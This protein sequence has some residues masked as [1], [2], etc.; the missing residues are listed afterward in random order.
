MVQQMNFEKNAKGVPRVRIELTAF[1][2]LVF[3]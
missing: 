3:V 1:R 2:L